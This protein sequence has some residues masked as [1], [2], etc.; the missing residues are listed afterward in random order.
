MI[1]RSALSTILIWLL[2]SSVCYA[3]TLYVK[4]IIQITVRTGP[5]ID[6]KVIALLKTGDR[7]ELIKQ[8]GDWYLVRFSKDRE[9]WVLARYLIEEI[10][11]SLLA[12]KLKSEQKTDKELINKLKEENRALKR[13]NKIVTAQLAETR[14]NFDEL[15]EG[16]EDYLNLKE[17]H[18]KTKNKLGELITSGEQLAFENKV[19]KDVKNIKWFLSGG[20]VMLS[21]W[22]I[23]FIMGRSKRKK[24]S[25]LTFSLKD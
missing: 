23:G 21:G 5:A 10:P 6:Y 17:E 4:D 14:K 12:Q 1:F 8:S 16:A 18:E 22:L 2:F 9:G 13:K 20:G 19:L 25:E 7:V 3:K 11:N 15:R 24:K